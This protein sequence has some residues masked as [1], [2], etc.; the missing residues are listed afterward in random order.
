VILGDNGA[1]KSSLVDALQ[2]A[3]QFQLPGV[4]GAKATATAGRCGLSDRLPRV[5]VRLTDGAAVERHVTYDD[6]RDR[7][8]VNSDLA[9]DFAHTPLI[10]RRSDILRFWDT[11]AELRQMVFVHYFRPGQRPVEL[12]QERALRLRAAQQRAKAQRNDARNALARVAD[13][14]PV[15]IPT[16]TTKF[17]NFVNSRLYGR[18]RT[19]S[20]D[21][22]GRLQPDVYAAV[23]QM[24]STLKELR[25]LK[26][27]A[28]APIRTETDPDS[29]LGAVLREASADVTT[30]FRAISPSAAVASIELALGEDTTMQ[31]AVRATLANGAAADP[32]RIL[33]EANRDL[34]AFLIFVAIAKASAAR[35]QAQVMVLDD[36]FQ[37]VDGPIRVAALD[38]VVSDLKGWQ[39]VLTAHDRLWREQVLSIMRRH[40]HPTISLEIA[41]W[42]P[43]FGPDIRATTGDLGGAVR[44]ALD[45]A[46]PVAI[47]VHAGR[48]V[49]LIGHHLSWILPV[50][51]SRRRDDRYTLNDVWPP[52]F[53][54]LKKLAGTGGADEVERY[55]HLRNLLGAHINEWAGMTSL[56][57]TR[58]FG[59][60]ALDLLNSVHCTEC[61]RWVEKSPETHTYVCRCGATRLTKP[62]S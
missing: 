28:D 34:V 22:P 21:K 30:A 11:P 41:G 4:R 59:D 10:L 38:Y 7:Y 45:T 56:T 20:G 57:E 37:S 39:F 44:A 14:S 19:E 26:K 2:F 24:R 46:D 51:V 47:A 53:S 36:V 43:E 15:E 35:G 48:L 6:E 27:E 62:S 49:E 33:S 25:Q 52:V 5:T 1:G 55:L 61:L 40:G 3:L 42:E 58:R 60:A 23:V 9:D 32:A 13:V 50:S 54:K 17:E 29:Q 31:L 16:D 12:P 18:S 8:V